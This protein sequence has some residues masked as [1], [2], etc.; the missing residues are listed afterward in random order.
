MDGWMEISS[1]HWVNY[2]VSVSLGAVRK[3]FLTQSTFYGWS[4]EFKES[5]LV[6]W[7]PHWLSKTPGRQSRLNKQ[8]V[9]IG[10]V[11]F[12]TADQ[13][14]SMFYFWTE[15]D[16]VIQRFPATAA[17]HT[18]EWFESSYLMWRHLPKCQSIPLMLMHPRYLR[19]SVHH[20]QHLFV[21]N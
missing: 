20:R 5:V 15:P 21:R 16:S 13:H 10:R 2:R 6:A 17:A 1:D 7:Q 4:S 12:R 11:R 8:D 3:W 9:T 19:C 18:D 14:F